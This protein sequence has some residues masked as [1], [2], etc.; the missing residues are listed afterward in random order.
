MDILRQSTAVTK[1]MGPFVDD[2]DGSTEETGLAIVQADVHLSKNGGDFAQ[3][4][5]A[6]AG[7]HDEKG[8]YLITFNATDINTLGSLR[9]TIH[10][11]GALPVWK[12]FMVFTQ[13]AYDA[14]MHA[15]DGSIR[16]EGIEITNI[17]HDS[18]TI[19]RES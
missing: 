13:K 7:V 3:K 16:A 12:D 11:T 1:K 17:D 14:L 4:N 9:V 15:T 5:D 18:T 19:V 8:Y 10:K 6:T 2:T